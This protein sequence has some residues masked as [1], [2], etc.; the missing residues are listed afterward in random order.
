MTIVLLLPVIDASDASSIFVKSFDWYL[1]S[2]NER[3]ALVI[4]GSQLVMGCEF[5]KL[6]REMLYNVIIKPATSDLGVLSKCLATD[7]Q[8]VAL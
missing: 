3:H 5:S 2:S 4:W 1:E 8:C 7:I 6:G